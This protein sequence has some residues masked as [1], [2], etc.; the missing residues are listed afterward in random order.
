MHIRFEKNANTK[1]D[2]EI[3]SLSWMGRVPDNAEEEG[4]NLDGRNYYQQGWLATGNAQGIVGVTFTSVRTSYESTNE[5]FPLRTNY[6]LRNHHAKVVLVKWNEPYQKLASC[7]SSG[8]IN[9]W[10]KFDCRW[11]VELINDRNTRVT[12]FSWSHDGRLALICYQDGFVLVGSVTGHRYWSSMLN[13]EGTVTCG[14]WSPDD[15]QVYFGTSKGQ[16]KVLDIHG[17]PVSQVNLADDSGISSMAWSCEKFCMNETQRKSDYLFKHMLAICCKNGS[18][19]LMRRYDDPAPI[20]IHTGLCPIYMEWAN[21]KELLCVAGSVPAKPG[22]NIIQIYSDTGQLVYSINLPFTT[23]EVTAV[24]WAHNDRRIF[25][26]TGP[27]IHV[28]C[29][30]AS[31][32]PLHI[33]C[34]LRL[35][36]ESKFPP[37]E[38]L[39]ISIQDTLTA[40]SSSTIFCEVPK[41][42]ELRHFVSS[43]PKNRLYCTVVQHVNGPETTPPSTVCYVLY[44]EY[45][46]GLVPLLK[47]KRI[48]ILKPEFVIFDPQVDDATYNSAQIT[49]NH[50]G[51]DDSESDVCSSPKL[52]RK[53]RHKSKNFSNRQLQLNCYTDVLPEDYRL[54]EVTANVWG[55]KFHI[56]G[57]C[58]DL[59]KKLGRVS[60]RTS[61]LHLQPRQM[62]LSIVGDGLSLTNNSSSHQ[63]F[64][65]QRSCSVGSSNPK[66]TVSR[67]MEDTKVS[68]T[69]AHS[70]PASPVTAKKKTGSPSPIR[71]RLM[72]SPLFF[73][74]VLRTQIE[75]DYQNLET[76]QKSQI[77]NKI[78]MCSKKQQFVM[79]N[80]APIWN[81]LT[82][83]YQLDFGGRVTQESAKNFQVE[84]NGIQVMQFG[85]IDRNNFALDFQY[86]FS[87]VQAFAVALASVT[88]R[89][90]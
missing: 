89:L 41:L 50:F 85:R 62:T 6:N 13:P 63:Q 79:H 87:A 75:P 32:L 53:N 90:K 18:I 66:V 86:P 7:D 74:K 12:Y 77:K 31:I 3:L 65:R 15:Q 70:L 11:N 27:E 47:G 68:E 84:Y 67:V 30:S 46:G 24:T 39:P 25:I 37:S 38:L 82:Q 81:D 34:A 2:S 49:Y 36:D 71:K 14:A 23:M 69:F 5:R 76:F 43:S 8:V 9:V 19:Q 45:L 58:D 48:S 29:V 78:N 72:N 40:I 28:A 17:T 52:H 16:M 35:F 57:L 59:T 33:L 61:I 83:V 44:M 42:S 80:K 73:R 54:A 21:S 26:A 64:Q 22:H 56:R 88:Q 20:L 10:A 60:Y 51:W 1:C 55:T 4:W